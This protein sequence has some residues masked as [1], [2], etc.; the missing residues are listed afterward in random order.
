LRRK[1][2]TCAGRIRVWS[3]N[4][5]PLMTGASGGGCGPGN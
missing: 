3:M 2:T 5:I 1:V 4:D